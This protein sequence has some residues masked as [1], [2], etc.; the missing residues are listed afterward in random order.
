MSIKLDETDIFSLQAFSSD[1]EH[2][3]IEGEADIANVSYMTNFV[4]CKLIM[5]PAAAK[6]LSVDEIDRLDSVIPLLFK[7]TPEDEKESM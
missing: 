1:I 6:S 2:M 4:L 5:S 3:M 7:I